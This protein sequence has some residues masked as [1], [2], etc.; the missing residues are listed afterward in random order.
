MRCFHENA[1]GCRSAVKRSVISSNHEKTWKLSTITITALLLLPSSKKSVGASHVYSSYSLGPL[2]RTSLGTWVQNDLRPFR[3]VE[4]IPRKREL[5]FEKNDPFTCCGKR[6]KRSEPMFPLLEL[7]LHVIEVVID[8]LSL[9]E[10]IAFKMCSWTTKSIV[11]GY[12]HRRR[13]ISITVEEFHRLFPHIDPDLEQF[14][15]IF[16]IRDELGKFLRMLPQ[17]RIVEADFSGLRRFHRELMEEVMIRHHLDACSLFSGV[18]RMSFNGCMV[19]CADL[20]SLSYCMQNL[21]SL[22]LSDRLIDHQLN[23]EDV[24][25]NRIQN[26]HAY[27]KNGLIGHRGRTIAHLKMLWPTLVRLTFV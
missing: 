17:N 18:T 22:T 24:D 16:H 14:D 1:P 2:M 15:S 11:D 27:Q 4:R 6:S 10:M 3:D 13:S 23:G 25:P 20:E 12:W 26:F 7:P 19:S 9:V 21:Q 8:K 5:H